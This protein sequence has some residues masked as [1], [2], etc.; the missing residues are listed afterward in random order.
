MFD[1]GTKRLGVILTL[2]FVLFTVFSGLGYAQPERGGW[3]T[4]PE[5][6]H[7]QRILVRFADLVTAEAAVE[8]LESLGYA[9][10]DVV[11]FRPSAQFPSGLRLGIVELSERVSVE[12]AIS[13]LSAMPGI[14]Y[15]EPDY[16]RYPSGQTQSEPLFPN[17]TYFDRMWGLHNHN[18]QY[19]DP[20]MPGGQPVDDADIDAPEAWPFH[21]GGGEV[22][23]AII[24]T[25]CYIDHPD[26]APNVW[27]NE[28]EWNGTP[29]V[30]D[31][32]NGYIDDFWGWNFFSD[33]NQVF[34]PNERDIYGYLND[35]HG[36]HVAGTIGAVSNNSMGVAGIN[37]DVQIMALKFL[38]PS[39]GYTSDAIKA[40][41]YATAMGV[42]VINCSWGGGGFNQA[43]K[44]AIEASG[45]LVVC[46]AGND[47]YDTD[48]YPH[49]PASYD[50][51]NIIAVG[52]MM[53]NE[54]VA[55]Y[56]NWWSSNYGVETVDL[57][58][59]GGYI[60]STVPPDPVPVEPTEAYA[61]FYGTSMASPHVTGTAA[62]LHSFRPD[63]PLYQG[64]P[65]WTPGTPTIKD[66]ILST[67]DV[68]PA[69]QGLVATNG[70]LNLAK[71][72]QEVAG[73]RI[74][75]F[76]V[77][78]L[79][80]PPPLEVTCS[81]SAESTEGEIVDVWW[82]FGDGSEPVYDYEA[83]HT[84][85]EEGEFTVSFH[86]LNDTG[87][88]VSRS[89]TIRVFHPPVISVEPTELETYVEW[90]QSEDRTITIANSG[91]GALNYRAMVQLV[92]M[93]DTNKPLG[94]G[95][96]DGYGYFWLDTNE[97]G[98]SVPEWLEISEIGTRLNLGGDEGIRVDLPFEFPFYGEMKSSVMVS[99]NGYLTFGSTGGSWTNTS[100]PN[101]NEPNEL[102]AV[103]WD[104]LEP[105]NAPGSV[106]YYGDEEKFV[107][108]YQ[109]VPRY[110]SGGPYTFQVTLT[111]G[112]T[113]TYHYKEMQG[114]R[115]NEA[116][117]GIENSDGTDGLQVAY[118]EA[119]VQDNMAV[120]F[121]PGWL[122]LD[123]TAGIVEPGGT[124][125]I[126]AT[127]AAHNLPQGTYQAMIEIQSN[128]P[129]NPV[130][131]VDTFMFAKSIIPP[132]IT[133][134]TADPWAGSAPL[135]VQFS[136]VVEDVDGEVVSMEWDFGDGSPV[137]T[138]ELNPVHIYQEEGEYEAVLTITDDDG[139][140]ASANLSIVVQDLPKA[141]V[142][143]D[144][145]WLVLR[146][147]RG[148][149]EVLTVTNVGVAPLNI[150]A[151]AA[152]LAE[153]GT[154]GRGGPDGFGYIWVDSRDS[155][156]PEYAWV[157]I[158][159]IGTK[160]NFVSGDSGIQV[161]LPFE[162]PFY[163]DVKTEVMVAADGYLTFGT[164]GSVYT[165]RPIP[166]TAEPNDLLA[167]YWDDLNVPQGPADGGVFHYYDQANDRFIVQWE[168]VPR[169]YNYG[170]YTFQAILYPDG[171]ITY[172]YK[173]MIFD[174]PSYAAD[175]TIGIE[176]A[177]GTDG[178]QILY[179]TAGYMEDG[180]AIKIYP[181]QWLS[182]NPEQ[183]V[184]QPGESVEFDVDID[185]SAIGGGVLK[186]SIV[187]E[188]DDI[189]EPRLLVPVTVEVLENAA[190]II[191]AAGVNPDT[192]PVTTVFEF[193]AAATDPDGYIADKWWDFGDGS[194]PV[195]EFAAQHSY[196][197][198]GQ[199]TAV[200]TAVDN[201][202]YQASTEVQVL[203]Q[204]A[205]TASWTPR[206]F[207][208]D[209]A[210][211][212]L[213]QDI[214]LLSNAGPGTLYFGSG[215]A[216]N[217]VPE[218]ERLVTPEKVQDANAR[219][220]AGLFAPVADPS[221]SPYLP[222]GVGNVITSWY[223]PAVIVTPWG[224]GTLL[225]SNDVVISDVESTPT[226]DY[227]VTP[228]GEYTGRSWVAS[229]GGSWP[230]DMAFDGRY[231]WQ[232]N[233][234]GDNAIYKIDPQTGEQVG[235]ISGS[236]WTSI[237]QRGLAYNANDDTFYIGGW[238]E[239][240]IYK[241]KGESW[242]NPGEIIEQWSMA[243][244][245]AGLAYHPVVNV[246]I[247][248]T[249]SAPDMIYF[250]DPESRAVLAQIPHPA[251][252]DY[253]GIG[254]EL[255]RDGNLW[256][257][258]LDTGMLY[259][260]DT[261]L[262][263]IGGG[264]LTWEPREG[265]VPAGASLPITVQVDTSDLGAGTYTGKVVLTTNDREN[266]LIMVPVTLSVPAP[267][268][269][270][271]VSADPVMGEPPLE[272]NFQA[273]Y[274]APEIPVTSVGWDFGDGGSS[275][276]P[277]TTH[278]YTEP[279]LYKAVFFVED[280]RGARVEESVEIEVTW[281]PHAA[282]EPTI[283]ELTLNPRET[284]VQTVVLSN[285][286]GN[287]ALE[288]AVDVRGGLAPVI[289]LPQRL[290]TV[291]DPLA[292]SARGLYR[293][294]DAGLVERIAAN[295]RPG[296]VGD[297]VT[298]WPVSSEVSLPWG[299][300]FDDSRVWISDPELLNNH[301]FTP[302]GAHTGSIFS[303]P[304]VG[305]WNGDM[306]WDPNRN[307]MWQVNVGGDNGIYALDPATGA[308][309]MSITSGMWTSVSQRG[310]A[311][312]ADTDTFYIGGWNEDIIYKV[313]GP[314]YSNPGDVL[315]AWSFPVSI[316]GLAWHP[317]GILWVTTNSAPDMIYALDLEALAV[318]HQVP[319]P[320]GG[321]Y[322][323]AGLALNSDGN[324]WVTSMKDN[325][326]YLVN[327]EMPLAKGIEVE[328]KR[329]TVEAGLTQELTVTI[330]AAALGEPGSVVEQHL[331]ITTN[332]PENPQLYVDLII[333]IEPGPTIVEAS[334]EPTIGEPPLTVAFAAEVE[335]GAA[336]IVDFWWDFGDGSE[337]VHALTCE[338]VY[339]ELGTYKASFHVLDANEVEVVEEFTITVAWLPVLGI[340]PEEFEEVVQV[341]E[342]MQQVLT[343][344][345]SGNSAMDFSI[346]TMPSFAG[347]PEWMRYIASEPVKGDY[348]A[349]PHGYAG[350]GAGGPDQFGYIWIDSKQAGG[351]VFDWFDISAVGT[352][353]SLTD[354]SQR[355]VSLPFD[356]PFYGEL[357]RTVQV[358]SNGYLTFQSGGSSVWNNTPIP[359]PSAPNDLVAVFWDDL[360]PGT[361]GDVYYYYDA[362]GDRFIVQFQGVGRWAQTGVA[363]TFQVLLYPDGTIIYQYLDMVGDL[364]S[365]TVGIEDATGTDGLQVVYNAAYIENELA[366]AFAPVGSILRVNP[367]AGYLL[368]GSSQ[369]VILTIGSPQAAAGTY[370]LYL[371]VA[372]NDPF[373][374]FAAVPVTLKVN[375]PPQ[376]TILD[377]QA[378]DELHG[379]TEIKWT[380]VDPDDAAE[381]LLIDLFW[382][383]GVEWNEIATGLANTG[384]FQW[385]SLEVGEA[386][387]NFRLMIIASD[388]SGGFS[389][390]ITGEF[391][392][393][394]EAPTAAFSFTPDPA[395]RLDVVQFTDESTDDGWIV[396]WHW[397]FG[398]GTESEE[399]N[400]EHRYT[401][402][403]TYEITL[404]VTDNGGLTASATKTIQVGN[405]A[406]KAAFRFEP[407]EP[408]VGEAVQFI[409][410]SSD[411]TEITAC[412]WDF[413]DG[414]TSSE[415]EPVHSFSSAGTFT[416]KL[417][418]IDEDNS[419]GSVEREITVVLRNQ[420]PEANFTFAPSPATRLDVVQF[421]DESTDDGQIVAWL[422]SFG[423]GAESEE[424]HPT[425]RYTELGVYE[426][427][428]T[429][430]DDGGLTATAAKTIEVVNMAPE[431]TILRPT[432]GQVLVGEQVVQWR[433]E[434]ADDAHDLEITLEYRALP[435]GDWQQIAT[436]QNT[437]QFLWDVSELAGGRYVLRITAVDPWGASAEA[438]SDEFIVAYLRQTLTAAPNP[439][440]DMV[441]FFYDL[442]TD[443]TLYVYSIAGRLVYSAQLSAA[444]HSH[445]WNLQ[446]GGTPVANGVYIYFTI[447]GGSRSET[448]RLVVSR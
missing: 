244:G 356:F 223:A 403:G 48:V 411:D 52:A 430:T 299:A 155:G 241:I 115:L 240:I 280:E 199:Y 35:E 16:I 20:R 301:L 39:G 330:D 76:S 317:D 28:V 270:V 228:A 216:A 225:D 9:L 61:F 80:G 191:T 160:L 435:D 294:F 354:E 327:T 178:L 351:P 185:L 165:N 274:E 197:Q 151:E 73:P 31:D 245:I 65:G 23:V 6:Y 56:P 358:C 193:V 404:T 237:S 423:D 324:L 373:R 15:A 141:E 261:G 114:T 332:D 372:A 448:G 200:F 425:H 146:A 399:Q 37:W 352:R 97:P 24:D 123:K 277:V 83:V 335:P 410:E 422:W 68:K 424:Q 229:F 38:G 174:S 362:E 145:I 170:S 124:D 176:N 188:T 428:L 366:V 394:N 169:Y 133:S 119:Y 71:A 26:L 108:Q 290:G 437:G 345:N 86:V 255:D 263:P 4:G 236:I 409:N 429:V 438:I 313:A 238:N 88:E 64:A 446:S 393:I 203:V 45:A 447:A 304:W 95:G 161:D 77:E 252:T 264:W 181:Y 340:Y 139:L 377:P 102:I 50:S 397:D 183:A 122:T 149:D 127:F 166:Y 111:P 300:G 246:L 129:E 59:P 32:G 243:V 194:E 201:D 289:A 94:S 419:A 213:G 41:E 173:E 79:Y 250:V 346:T 99:S 426:I 93:V 162:F 55:D 306:A 78:P 87:M 132:R 74:T 112:G 44:D 349:E 401:E 40:F 84:Y 382:T 257:G 378:G 62:L 3:Q 90:G 231:I 436:V 116:T 27:V 296:A 66:V 167:V 387:D 350:A 214:L 164:S 104:D 256:V 402:M 291:S 57:F 7:P 186:G 157:E 210:K 303:T 254:A 14:L 211:G 444:A 113:I 212:Q 268:A 338:Y 130:V 445:E 266:P 51:P 220:A 18:T 322:S 418:V 247:V 163:G 187:L 265:S 189:R 364:T 125:E 365:A 184:V 286:E 319:H 75:A 386:G 2:V 89:A 10:R 72:L 91:L 369:D 334:A 323:G 278:T 315:D 439:A 363:Y 29:G 284:S 172:Q 25:G 307:L 33:N 134:L 325:Y 175:G 413:G 118:D 400:P 12:E 8:S 218:L 171:S 226:M 318:V 109:T 368:P 208:F 49:Y 196:A 47:G 283:I 251:G 260:V 106:Y 249:N 396:A 98:V 242:D 101:T 148:T 292:S 326:V 13:R 233:V 81:A 143:P 234:G 395:T 273:V 427:V 297:V 259:L 385:N 53:Q 353:I 275:A 248:T 30:D 407:E 392:I 54:E 120:F 279:G 207:R 222:D 117:I 96:P 217:K 258:N 312:D 198:E 69:Y 1:S 85:E 202:G 17:D 150:R 153:E 137:A 415:W 311:Y 82:D 370:S 121:V 417:T 205:A 42:D 140:V 371:Y 180:L 190:P 60:L 152:T 288:F 310:L 128:D 375:A 331:V 177:A 405:A 309:V 432:A 341:G 267:P 381:D 308:V 329:G 276:E 36:S 295:V 374:P 361:A 136:A 192:G 168:Q 342:E 367:D 135:T 70:R 388:P 434:D 383:R 384:S 179:N 221:R 293:A 347:S 406:P 142:E 159:D 391:T 195:H 343:V 337:P 110:S 414:T 431:V 227:V 314:S 144:S 235:K 156:G 209:L 344:S 206:S 339:S 224:I 58:A 219:T 154:L 272:V 158:K 333:T 421:T 19:I 5:L 11:D 298:S 328:P 107:V 287:A 105:Q 271:A 398:D 43:L 46:A 230:G 262:G 281:L 232:V 269:I 131:T 357:K 63:L 182:V 253:V 103:F 443:G 282:V 442:P 420:Q 348:A 34:D 412:F 441:T 376:V 379:L 215:E 390:D 92:G 321:D 204:A 440:S 336:E 408:G 302:A 305:A 285:A 138:G 239:D 320:F 100:I 360:D 389:E 355:Q 359:D 22:L 67:V 380:A 433:A 416:V 126:T 316:A 21:T 147:H